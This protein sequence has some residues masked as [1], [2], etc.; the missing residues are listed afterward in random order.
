M[1]QSQ[2]IALIQDW[3]SW[4]GRI[5]DGKYP[6]R[7]FLADSAGT[8]VY[9]TEINGAT[10]VIKLLA[11]DAANARAQLASWKL[12]ERLSHPNLVRVFE[13]G[14]WHAD[15]EH[16]LQF[17]VMEYCEE[18]LDAV[19]GQRPLTPGETRQMLL[20]ALDALKYLHHNGILHG[21]ISPPNILASG[22]QLKLST[23]YLRRCTDTDSVLVCGP[24]DAPEGT[25]GTISLSSDIWALGM[26]LH[27]V[28]T[29]RLASRKKDG[30]VEISEKLA[31]PFDEIVKQ[32]LT[33][34]R[35]RRPSIAA[36]SSMP[37]RPAPVLVTSK[38]L[39]VEA[40][41]GPAADIRMM[42]PDT[43]TCTVEPEL[44]EATTRS[45][46][47][48]W[49]KHPA[50]IAAAALVVL[51]A[52]SLGVRHKEP[53]ATVS[54]SATADNTRQEIASPAPAKHGLVKA[55]SGNLG[56]SSG[57]VLHEVMPDIS[58]QARN[59]IHGTVKVRV[60]LDV[61]ADGKVARAALAANSPSAYFARQALAAARE[62]TFAPPTR[63]GRSQ[64]S[65]W[66]LHFEFRGN[67][68]RA[69]AQRV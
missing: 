36:I 50:L 53:K 33:S 63:D 26:T 31:S 2:P 5:V 46:L 17:A 6:L 12:A 38:A 35:E 9:L 43:P 15:D 68:T 59:T 7:Q 21:Q 28:L 37:E 20:P 1:T 19:L 30:A 69:N 52:I 18:S 24:Y 23:D 61:T 58:A 54:S 27:E 32:C 66:M 48:V 13:T 57:S 55:G 8:A 56:S 22:D 34:D 40:N 11:A 51:F 45:W 67:G 3:R 10:A 49:E 14:L 41:S 42:R 60:K 64:A 39:P 4:D 44:S 29:Q 62:W 25:T 16:D 47:R 65:E